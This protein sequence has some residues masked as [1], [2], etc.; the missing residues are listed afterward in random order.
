MFLIKKS[1][2]N[3]DVNDITNEISP[4][5]FIKEENS[6][7]KHL[8]EV[9]D[10][11]KTYGKNEVLKG[12]NFTINENEHLVILGSNG[13]GKTVTVE[14]IAGLIKSTSGTIKYNFD[15]EIDLN[16][17]IGVQFQAIDFPSSLTPMDVIDF[18]KDLLKIEIKKEELDEL[19]DTFKIG[20]FINRKCSK[21]SGGQKQRLNVLLSLLSK[22]R[23]VFLDEFST[24]LDFLIKSQ[25]EEFILKYA[26][27]HNI[28]IV[29]VSHDVNEIEFFA[30]KIVVLHRGKI[31]LSATKEEVLEEFGSIRNVMLEYI[32]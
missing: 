23:V 21:L 4:K 28:T 27:K 26:K 16:K 2:K 10:V 20:K 11:Y 22:P 30:K 25:I 18:Q 14:T 15:S 29:L 32:K 24:G 1:E 6:N 8:V 5:L 9:K 17:Q 3:I 7:V 12:I 13:A 19:I 31:I